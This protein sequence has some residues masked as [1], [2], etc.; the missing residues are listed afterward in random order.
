MTTKLP[1]SLINIRK[2][3]RAKM[4]IVVAWIKT[5]LNLNIDEYYERHVLN[6]TVTDIHIRHD[7]DYVEM[8]P[9]DDDPHGILY[10]VYTSQVLQLNISIEKWTQVLKTISN[11]Q[12]I[13]KYRIHK[14]IIIETDVGNHFTL[15]NHIE[16]I[17]YN[18]NHMSI[19][20]EFRIYHKFK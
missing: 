1:R 13:G 5:H 19:S 14:D 3:H 11:H 20:I 10:H 16:Y 4:K 17:D 6:T 15:Q 12:F 2:E 7:N 9:L 18:F 8:G